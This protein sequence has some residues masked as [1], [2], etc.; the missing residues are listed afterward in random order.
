M[1]TARALRAGDREFDSGSSQSYLYLS[2]PS[3]VLS[4]NMV[5]QGLVSSVPGYCD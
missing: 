3:L 5:W 1:A 4:I 2:L